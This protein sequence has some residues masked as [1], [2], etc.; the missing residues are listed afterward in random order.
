MMVDK[1]FVDTGVFIAI[2]DKSDHSIAVAHFGEL[3]EVRK[4]LLTTNFTAMP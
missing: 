3:L 4:P 1:Q 2:T